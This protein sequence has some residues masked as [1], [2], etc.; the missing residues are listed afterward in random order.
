MAEVCHTV[1]LIIYTQQWGFQ[2][3][4]SVL[5]KRVQTVI[6]AEVSLCL[7]VVDLLRYFSWAEPQL[8]AMKALQHVSLPSHHVQ[9]NTVSFPCLC[10]SQS[11]LW[12]VSEKLG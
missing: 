9:S 3:L 12:F 2:V 4:R 8:K 6:G 5:E 10:M 11:K 7:Q 1:R